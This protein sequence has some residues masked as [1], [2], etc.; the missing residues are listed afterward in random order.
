M[1]YFNIEKFIERE[2]PVEKRSNSREMC[3]LCPRCED[4]V[5]KLY[6]NR[7][8]L[9]F[10]CHRCQFAGGPRNATKK[11]VRTA[12]PALR[13]I[14]RPPSYIRLMPQSKELYHNLIRDKP[15]IRKLLRNKNFRW[16][17]LQGWELGY[18]TNGPFTGRLI[19]PVYFNY[20]LVALQGRTLFNE[21]PK[22]KNRASTG[23]YTQIFYNWDRAKKNDTLVIVEGPFDAWRVGFNAIATL[24]TFLSSYRVGLINQLHP[25][26]VVIMYDADKA[27]QTAM[28]KASRKIFPTIEVLGAILPKKKDPADMERGVLLD[29]IAGAKK[30][31]MGQLFRD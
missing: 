12:P 20:K 10:F 16:E 18:C 24:G 15:E 14:K 31:T 7:E 3:F 25:K 9:K 28:Y 8:T 26:R 11:Y 5:G 29:L 17:D 21:D 4:T 23:V 1:A 19:I 22:Y 2:E 6:V 30:I 27:G 13:E